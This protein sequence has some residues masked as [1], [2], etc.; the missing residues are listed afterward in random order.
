MPKPNHRNKILNAGLAVFHE[1]GF[2]GCG[3][4]DIVTYAGVPKGSFYNHF[5]SKDALGLEI[6]K[7]YWEANAE[8]RAILHNEKVPA[9]ERIEKYLEATGYH[10]HGCLIGNF[11]SELAGAEAFRSS[12]DEL[13]QY[14]IKD[15]AACI[16]VG[17]QDGSI[18]KE[19]NP[20]NMAEFIIASLEGAILKTK[21][22][23]DQKILE[24]F[25]KFIRVFISK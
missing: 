25:R 4:Q 2:H 17:Q 5:K 15:V 9:I 24:R 22:S 6:L 8:K 10:E 13:Y 14:W 7:M 11:S 19:D 18:S 1:Q 20:E 21:V 3:I 16:K 12:L 23:R